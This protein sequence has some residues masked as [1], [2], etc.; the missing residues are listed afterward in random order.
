[1]RNEN[2][3]LKWVGIALGG[4]G[5]LFVGLGIYFVWYAHSAMWVET[6]ATVSSV[7]VRTT[8]HSAG[9]ALQRG[10]LYYPQIRYEYTVDGKRHNSQKWMLRTEH[11]SYAERD[12]AVRA[13][14]KYRNGEAI[15]AYYNRDDPSVAVLKPGV[16]LVDYVAL[17]MGLLL[18]LTGWALYRIRFHAAPP[19]R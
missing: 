19:T 4:L 10:N 9:D 17:L 12:E 3:L 14:A 2:G 8:V 5:A 1:M 15:V 6:T 13:A 18:G 16:T 11:E 7:K